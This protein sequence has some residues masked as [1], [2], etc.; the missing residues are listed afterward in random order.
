[1]LGVRPLLK[2]AVQKVVRQIITW[3]KH[4]SNYKMTYSVRQIQMYRMFLFLLDRLLER[5]NI[6]VCRRAA[7][8]SS[9]LSPSAGV[10]AAAVGLIWL[11][12]SQI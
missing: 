9:S 1:V 2:P 10:T 4:T 12:R 3:Q 6:Y 8:S 7:K 5:L 11:L